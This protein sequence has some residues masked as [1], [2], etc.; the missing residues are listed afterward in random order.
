MDDD[1]GLQWWAEMG[2]REVVEFEAWLDKVDSEKVMPVPAKQAVFKE[3]GNV[4]I[5]CK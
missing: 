1:G 2:Q 3:S 5:D 4:S